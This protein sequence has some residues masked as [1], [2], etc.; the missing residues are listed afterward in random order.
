MS[1]ITKK[2]YGKVNL[3][4]SVGE[5]R[6]DN[7]HNVLTVM[8]KISAHDTVTVRETEN[9][10]ITV[11]CDMSTL[12]VG[13]D[14]LV[15]KACEEY[16]RRMGKPVSVSA[17]I[18]KR[19]PVAGGMGGGSSD[20]A[21][22]LLALNE[23]YGALGFNVLVDIAAS[24]G[25]DIPFFLYDDRAMVGRGTGEKM[26]PCVSVKTDMYGVFVTGG[27]KRSTGAMYASLDAKKAEMKLSGSVL[28]SDNILCAL[29]NGDAFGIL[30][31]IRNDFEI[32][33]DGFGTVKAE[34]EAL[35]A[36]RAFLCGSGPTVCGIFLDKEKAEKADLGLDGKSFLAKIE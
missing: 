14:N 18:E 24:L 20:C 29:E 8:H 6:D 25:S 36:D 15:Y 32:C 19:I 5:L 3:F 11:T 12:S 21:A 31:E 13:R 27:Q 2:A 34:L 26:S 17:H 22:T 35:G 16:E 33:S 30:K 1:K 23:L 4:L 7:K 9:V 28:S 10:G